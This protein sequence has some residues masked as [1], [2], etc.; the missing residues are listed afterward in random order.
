LPTPLVR[1]SLI[2]MA[3]SEVAERK[4]YSGRYKKR[5]LQTALSPVTR[6]LSTALPSM[7]DVLDEKVDR[8][9][10]DELAELSASD[11]FLMLK[12]RAL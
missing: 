8:S 3:I 9:V 11:N 10:E 12:M 2:T 1:P 7:A 5:N 4:I 6:A